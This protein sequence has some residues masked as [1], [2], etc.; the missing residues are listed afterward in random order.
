MP[1]TA[2]DGLDIIKALTSYDFRVVA[3]TGSHVKLRLHRDDVPEVRTVTVPLK[4]KDD[5][6]TGT[7]RSIAEQCDADEY[8][9]WFERIDE[10]R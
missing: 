3:R 10:N 7:F 2:F 4:S 8:R 5:I 6:S 1:P 9:K